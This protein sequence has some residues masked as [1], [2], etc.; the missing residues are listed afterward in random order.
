MEV[1]KIIYD[2]MTVMESREMRKPGELLELFRAPKREVTRALISD[3]IAARRTA[4]LVHEADA[5]RC[6][7][8]NKF[9]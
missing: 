5:D 6:E 9:M 3:V 4:A 1:I 7:L 2:R 8:V